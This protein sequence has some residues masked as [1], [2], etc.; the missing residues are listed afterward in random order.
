MPR[1]PGRG[2][3][4]YHDSEYDLRKGLRETFANVK[5]KVADWLKSGSAEPPAIEDLLAWLNKHDPKFGAEV[6][7]YYDAI[8]DPQ[9]LEEQMVFLWNS[10]R[11]NQRTMAEELE[12]LVARGEKITEFRT[13]PGLPGAEHAEEFR[14]AIA[15][16]GPLLD[17]SQATQLHG[18]HV[19]MFHEFL[20]DRLFKRIGAGRAFRMRL[21]NYQK[22]PGKLIRAGQADQ[23]EKPFWSRLWDAMFDEERLS[24]FHDSDELGDILQS[25]LDFPEA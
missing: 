13:T 8:A 5:K 18:T 15:K 4:A 11:K 12:H 21:A 22:G 7:Q 24:G 14:K 3:R 23:Y 19:H 1:G 17:R 16:K 2:P 6:K 9:F 10:A 20:G 25:H